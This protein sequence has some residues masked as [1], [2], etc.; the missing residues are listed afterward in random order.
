[1]LPRALKHL[2]LFLE[3]IAIGGGHVETAE[4]IR[5]DDIHLYTG[6]PDHHGFGCS[7]AIRPGI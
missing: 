3:F 7:R 5:S 4:N 2:T 6:Q 1:M